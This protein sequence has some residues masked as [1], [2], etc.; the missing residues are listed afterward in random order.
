MPKRGRGG[1]WSAEHLNSLSA[2]LR[3]SVKLQD[4]SP[5]SRGRG[6]PREILNQNN[7]ALKVK[8][9]PSRLLRSRVHLKKNVE[10]GKTTRPYHFKNKF[11]E[12]LR[13][14][15]LNKTQQKISMSNSIG[16]IA[17]SSDNEITIRKSSS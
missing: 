10:L 5:G 13:I 4:R 6:R 7:W 1:R 2:D 9:V 3:S 12:K 17:S 11:R 16:N 14:L 15:R 8:A